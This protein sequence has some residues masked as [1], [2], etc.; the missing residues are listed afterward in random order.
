MFKSFRAYRSLMANDLLQERL[1]HP[2]IHGHPCPA[3]SSDVMLHRKLMSKE[4]TG[5]DLW[6]NHR[7]DKEERVDGPVTLLCC[8]QGAAISGEYIKEWKRK[9][10]S[11][12]RWQPGEVRDGYGRSAGWGVIRRGAMTERT[13]EELEKLSCSS[14][15][16]Q[17][18]IYYICSV[19]EFWNPTLPIICWELTVSPW[20]GFD[21]CVTRGEQR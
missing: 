8:T 20:N 17:L 4:V 3:S 11:H 1:W 19:Q 14:A 16:L 13:E 21:I 6:I 18:L 5:L 9:G 7:G 10:G 15:P 12:E 2:G